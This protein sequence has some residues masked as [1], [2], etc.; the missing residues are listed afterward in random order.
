MVSLLE[1]INQSPEIHRGHAAIT[2]L[3]PLCAA[4]LINRA[5]K[6]TGRPLFHFFVLSILLSH[7][8]SQTL[9]S[10]SGLC[11]QNVTTS[12]YKIVNFQALYWKKVAYGLACLCPCCYAPEQ[13]CVWL[14]VCVGARAL[15]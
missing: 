3:W 9:K 1:S 14:C 15:K 10:K 13:E 6:H 2:E 7:Y 12:Q 4:D 8:F 5:V 11:G